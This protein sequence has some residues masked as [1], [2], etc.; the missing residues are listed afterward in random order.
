V[1]LTFTRLSP[2]AGGIPNCTPTP[3]VG[4]GKFFF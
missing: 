4:S 3:M 1:S 2:A